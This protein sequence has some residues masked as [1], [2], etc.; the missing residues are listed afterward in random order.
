M[1]DAKRRLA[2][3]LHADVF[4]YSRL[5]AGDEAATLATLNEYRAAFREQI[6]AHDG[7]T[8][9]TSGD[10]V[11]AVFDSVVECTRAALAIQG[12]LAERNTVLPDERRMRFRI[13]I[14]L[15]DVIEQADGTIYGDGV[16]I[17]AR[18]ESLADPGGITLS[19]SAH[20]FVDGRI[21]A[22]FEFIGEHSVKN[23]AKP[24]RVYQMSGLVSSGTATASAGT[25]R[26]GLPARPSIAVLPFMNMG[27]NEEE[28]YFADGITEDI[29][30]ELSRFQELIVTARNTTFSYKGQAMKAPD[31]GRELRVRYILEGSVRRSGDRVRVNAQ[32][33]EAEN[34]Q[35][36]WAERFDRKLE[37]VF[38]VQDEL[39]AKIVATLIGRLQDSERRRAR[40][41]ADT[42]STE[43][44][45]LVLRGREFWYRM[46]QTDNAKA[47]ELYEQALELDPEYA[48]AYASLAWTW[49]ID[50]NEYWTDDSDG[51]LD[52]A[53]ELARRAVEMDPASHSNRLALGQV[54]YFRKQLERSI[55][56]FEKAIELNR[57]DPDCFAFL[58]QALSLNGQPER[59]IE[60]LD[61]AFALNS[62]LS[63]WHRTQYLIA[64]FNARRYDE[65]LEIIAE[66]DNPRPHYQRWI[67]ATHGW[68]GM[69][70]EARAVT[71]DYLEH[72]PRFELAEHLRRI[73]YT[74]AEDLEHYAE[75]LR[76][77]GLEHT[78]ETA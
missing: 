25:I 32:L 53:L 12:E 71:R 1:N 20:D 61:H 57:N 77:A 27:S 9:D 49:M 70:A 11:L 42:S 15:G 62:Y 47:R 76:R 38:A 39:T 30:T 51:A 73:P 58:S 72:Y 75:G 5:M 48:R 41:N 17:A 23:I 21:D 63:G 31:I 29:I 22:G 56:S 59:A 64:Y 50:Y 40:A 78:A 46:T 52:K 68:L 6:A 24:V 7:R 10:S 3:I 26:S 33:I 19:G 54:Y 36:V 69:E 16:N 4:G 35:H 2:A 8:V 60:V 37:D 28:V 45:E 13:G 14:N 18:L 55:E 43:A 65:A 74:H 44:Y 34:D 66:L 67:A